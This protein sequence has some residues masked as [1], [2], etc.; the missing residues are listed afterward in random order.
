MAIA[1]AFIGEMDQEV[2]TTRRVLE[3]VPSD[4]LA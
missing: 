1:D 3:R 2:G 4:K